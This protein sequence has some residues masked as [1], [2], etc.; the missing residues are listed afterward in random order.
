MKYSHEF[1]CWIWLQIRIVSYSLSLSPNI[2]Q[3][4]S[5]LDRAFKKFLHISG[6][7]FHSD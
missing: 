5:M 6:F 3:I 7:V 2:E 4:K 1:K